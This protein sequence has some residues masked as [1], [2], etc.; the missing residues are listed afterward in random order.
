MLALDMPNP[1]PL[2]FRGAAKYPNDDMLHPSNKWHYIDETGKDMGPVSLEEIK[3]MFYKDELLGTSRV[4]LPGMEE[5]SEIDKVPAL[6]GYLSEQRACAPFT[7]SGIAS[8]T[9]TVL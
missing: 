3:G 8:L 9:D 5:W 7:A 2:L 4:W 1:R 6:R